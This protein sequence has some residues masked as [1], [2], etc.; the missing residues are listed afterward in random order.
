M[1][2]MNKKS[3][4]SYKFLLTELVKKGIKLKYRR[5]YLGI[6]WSLIEPLLTTTVLV[7]VFGTLFKNKNPNYP[8][9]VIIGR[10]M[11]S[12]F[13]AGTNATMTSF[14]HNAGMM[15][16]VYI[17]K[18][19]YPVSTIIY[20]YVITGISLLVLI[21][22]DIYCGII[23]TWHLLQFIPAILLT[24]F[25]TFGIGLILACLNVFFDDIVYLWS[26]ALLLIM[27]MSAIFYYPEAILESKYSFILKVNPLF[28]T[29]QLGRDAFFAQAFNIKYCL[30]ALIWG[31]GTNTAGLLF[32]KANKDKF[33]LHL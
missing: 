30:T 19:I 20:N 6:L 27:Y 4:A 17:P 15:K 16:K 12:F 26:V 23:P 3:L 24:L 28:S 31:I 32:F 9:Y 18:L 21:P 2:A 5:S 10:L 1:N 13:S 25:F 7:I 8:M 29:I 11:Y 14:K 33:I 22:V